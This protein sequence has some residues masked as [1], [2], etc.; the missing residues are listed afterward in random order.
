MSSS[1]LKPR[2]IV[3]GGAGNITRKNL[4]S[5]A[6]KLYSS[7]LLAIHRSTSA[8]L[9]NGTTALDA[10]THAVALFEDSPLFNCAKGAV[11]ELAVV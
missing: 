3:H 7:A 6:W 4:D 9:S 11:S 8:L 1:T 5:H 10:A 2:L